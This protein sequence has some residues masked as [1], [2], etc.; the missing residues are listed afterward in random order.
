MLQCICYILQCI[1]LC[2]S[3]F[4]KTSI[5]E[6]LYIC[7]LSEYICLCIFWY[8][9][10]YFFVLK[11]ICDSLAYISLC[12]SVFLVYWSIFLCVCLWIC[13]FF[14]LQCIFWYIGVC[15]YLWL[16]PSPLNQ[17]TVYWGTTRG[18]ISN[19]FYLLWRLAIQT[20]FLGVPSSN[21][22]I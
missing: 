15:V 19:V 6:S 18:G 17:P 12:C 7:G 21:C 20:S 1:S 10:V 3:V 4:C 9:G 2:C 11:C 16:P 14:V 22:V 8:I 13:G 5:L